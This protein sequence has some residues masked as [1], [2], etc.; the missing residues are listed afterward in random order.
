MSDA[1]ERGPA[2]APG[3]ADSAGRATIARLATDTLPRLI[4]RLTR[5]EL[6]EL[7]VREDGWRI[8]LRR[9]AIGNGPASAQ[10]SAATPRTATTSHRSTGSASDRPGSGSVP[11]AAHPSRADVN[12][13]AVSSPAVGY[14]VARDG[15]DVGK[16][17]RRGDAV[18]YV[19]VLGVR[20]EVVS[21]LDGTL[22]AIDVEPGQAVEY[23]QQLARVEADVQ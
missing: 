18:G 16:P 11:R 13:G 7:E 8:R 2:A 1:E 20:H 3:T 15:A 4:D 6:G 14:F 19:D 17:L 21:P 10:G 5:S 12:R 23:G 22:R 9:P